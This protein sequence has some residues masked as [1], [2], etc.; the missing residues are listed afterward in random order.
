MCVGGCACVCVWIP[1]GVDHTGTR[2]RGVGV[3]GMME[4]GKVPRMECCP[5]CKVSGSLILFRSARG[6]VHA[7]RSGLPSVGLR[8]LCGRAG[9]SMDL[10]FLLSGRQF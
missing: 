5:L 2:A 7:V 4:F 10:T 9:P 1:L 6:V 3:G 8:C